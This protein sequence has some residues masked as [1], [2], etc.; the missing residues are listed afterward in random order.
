MTTTTHALKHNGAPYNDAAAL[1]HADPKVT[2][3]EGRALCTCGIL[4]E[5]LAT[6]AARRAWHKE[7]KAQAAA[8]EVAPASPE[9]LAQ[10]AWEADLPEQ[11]PETEVVLGQDVLV[12]TPTDEVAEA[13]AELV[14]EDVTLIVV[15]KK[16]SRRRKAEIAV[17]FLPE[18]GAPDEANATTDTLPFTTVITPGFWRSLGRDAAIA[19]VDACYP[20]VLVTANNNSRVLTLQGP[21]EDVPAAKALIEKL[22]ADAI[23]ATKEWKLTDAGFLGR[24]PEPLA[25][26]REGYHLT[27]DF[28]VAYGDRFAAEHCPPAA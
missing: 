23:A 10:A 8:A 17:G 25:R 18:V 16:N 24:S 4:S 20:T 22:W 9:P 11:A 27:E 2:S 19:V 6:G 26:R 12:G 7:H 14:G 28:Y 3:G 1:V 5:Q 21:S 15:P 13:L